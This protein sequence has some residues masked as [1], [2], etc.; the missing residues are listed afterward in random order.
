MWI[1]YKFMYCIF[2]S[3]SYLSII[4]LYLL[5]KYIL[6]SFFCICNL[7]CISLSHCV[8]LDL[9]PILISWKA[10]KRRL[11][12]QALLVMIVDITIIIIMIALIHTKCCGNIALQFLVTQLSNKVGYVII[13]IICIVVIAIIVFINNN[14]LI[15]ISKGGNI[16][17]ILMNKVV[18]RLLQY[19]AST[20]IV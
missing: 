9:F 14:I 19:R 2:Y 1:V 10:S 4:L 16:G 13:I 7:Y 5:N 15:I 12:H 20:I 18:P 3:L 6:L 17:P 11:V 8:K